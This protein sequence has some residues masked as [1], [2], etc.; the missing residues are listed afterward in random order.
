MTHPI[1]NEL[2]SHEEKVDMQ[3]KQPNRNT[4][5]VEYLDKNVVNEKLRS[6]VNK[7]S[8]SSITDKKLS[9]YALL[10]LFSYLY[11]NHW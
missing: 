11:N 1:K 6:A 4:E 3:E 5:K 8:I 9:Q 10:L 7:T 2:I